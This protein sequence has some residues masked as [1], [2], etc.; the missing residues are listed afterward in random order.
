M[1]KKCVEEYNS[2]IVIGSTA[3]R[4][5]WSSSEASASSDFVTKSLF[6]GGYSLFE[7]G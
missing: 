4:G 6:Q 5:P 2:I 1:M 3:L 7:E